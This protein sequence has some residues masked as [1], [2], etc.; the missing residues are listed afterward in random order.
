MGGKGHTE[1]VMGCGEVI[2]GKCGLYNHI[3]LQTCLTFSEIKEHSRRKKRV[4]LPDALH[5]GEGLS[6]TDQLHFSSPCR[7]YHKAHQSW[8]LCRESG[9]A[10][11]TAYS[12]CHKVAVQ[13]KARKTFNARQGHL[14]LHKQL[15]SWV[16]PWLV[17]QSLGVLGALIG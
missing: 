17:V 4:V 13:T 15:E 3:S 7:E 16:P 6:S 10:T 14:L 12:T 1:W 9:E 11:G 2:R 5:L 8:D